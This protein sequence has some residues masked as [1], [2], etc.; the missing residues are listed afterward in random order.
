MRL[1]LCLCLTVSLGLLSKAHM[2]LQ[3]D[4]DLSAYAMPDGTLPVLC[5]DGGADDAKMGHCPDCQ[6]GALAD[7]PVVSVGW[8]IVP[9]VYRPALPAPL[10]AQ[11]AEIAPQARGPPSVLM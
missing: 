7:L 3:D 10:L 2:P 4:A 1:I 5:S 6:S 11:K 9:R 8:Q